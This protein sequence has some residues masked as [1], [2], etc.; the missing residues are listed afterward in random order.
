[1]LLLGQSGSSGDLALLPEST[2][3]LDGSA[4]GT[5][6]GS[7]SGIAYT[8]LTIQP[9]SVI[10]DGA[11]QTFT[12]VT[13]V[14]AAYAILIEQYRGNVVSE[15]TAEHK[16]NADNSETTPKDNYTSV[17]KD[18]ETSVEEYAFTFTT[19]GGAEAIFTLRGNELTDKATGESHILTQEQLSRLKD[20]LGI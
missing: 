8:E 12:D 14:H 4:T 15:S 7:G 3:Q 16:G 20:A 10:G 11:E 18:T 13:Q 19:P 17:S 5:L 9:C 1:M 2:P 6:N